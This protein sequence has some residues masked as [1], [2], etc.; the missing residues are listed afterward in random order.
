M[1]RQSLK[2]RSHR[3]SQKRFEEFKRIQKSLKRLEARIW[4]GRYA[5]LLTF[6]EKE[7]IKD[8]LFYSIILLPPGYKVRAVTD[9]LLAKTKSIYYKICKLVR[10]AGVRRRPRPP[11]KV[12]VR[13]SLQNQISDTRKP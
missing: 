11:P 10:L 7:K 2:K 6:E 8:L 5:T 13:K 1:A 3:Y 9:K 12:I 4:F